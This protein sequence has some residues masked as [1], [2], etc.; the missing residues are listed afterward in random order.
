[1]VGAC[2]RTVPPPNPCCG[3]PL[4]SPAATLLCLATLALA[5]IFSAAGHVVRAPRESGALRC[6]RWLTYVAIIPPCLRKESM[7]TLRHC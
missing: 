6:L 4:C 3:P 2:E 7:L 1:M 5:L